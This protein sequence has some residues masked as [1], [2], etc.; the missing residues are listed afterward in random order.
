MKIL[1]GTDT[2]PPT[3]NGAARFTERYAH[4]LA[5]RGHEVHVVCPS[6]SG[7][8]ADVDHASVHVHEVP[9]FGY[10]LYDGFRISR[11]R[12]AARRTEQVVRDV[13]PDVVHIQDNFLIGR[14][15]AAACRRQQVP[16]VATNHLMPA[17]FFDHV[18]VPAF[19][20]AFGA[21]RLW[22]DVAHVYKHAQVVTSPTPRAVDLLV[23][24]TGFE[25]AV[26]V[27]NGIDQAPYQAAA[28]ACRRR[29]GLHAE[30]PTVLFV[31]RLDQEKRVGELL[32]AFALIPSTTPAR[33]EI[34]GTGS[35]RG[36]LEQQAAALGLGPGRVDFRGFVTD[37]E[38]LQ[39]Y[40]RADVFCMPGVAELQSLVTLE[41]MAAGKPVVAADAMALPHLCRPGLNGYLFAPGDV[42]ELAGHL[43]TLL[44]N[45][46]LRHRMGQASTRIVADHGFAS[47]IGQFERLYDQVRAPL[48]LDHA[49]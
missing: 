30:T 14:G 43:T 33:L 6:P 40:G 38:L 36:R 23:E 9:S 17:N 27:S 20:R 44:T 21:R 29:P 48:S 31:G 41:A 24:A 8:S 4:A 42:E 25:H 35:L 2:Y 22:A 47:T 12:A 11:P 15:L 18:P 1:L 46:D 10:P 16:L 13:A 28:A 34:V 3:V 7:P 5:A 19:L 32:E 37:D 45:P 49:A 26:A 39:A